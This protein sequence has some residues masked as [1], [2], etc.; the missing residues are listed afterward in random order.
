MREVGLDISKNSLNGVEWNSLTYAG[1]IAGKKSIKA[2]RIDGA[3]LAQVSADLQSPTF[4][5]SLT[6]S[7]HRAVKL[8]NDDAEG[9]SIRT[10]IK[11]LDAKINKLSDLLS[12]TTA[13]ESLIKK[14][15]NLQTGG[16][17]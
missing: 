1:H 3:V 15:K 2:K 10:V 9:E 17:R 5:K 12:E 7:A 11:K 8:T 6:E 13:T 4:I 16:I 14:L